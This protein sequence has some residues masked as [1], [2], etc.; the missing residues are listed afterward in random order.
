M[1][2]R[3]HRSPLWIHP[4]WW[5]WHPR[6]MTYLS[7]ELDEYLDG[8]CQCVGLRPGCARLV[9]I[10]L[11]LSFPNDLQKV[12]KSCSQERFKKVKCEKK[13]MPLQKLLCQHKNQFY[14][15]SKDHLLFWHKMFCTATACT[16]CKWIFGTTQKIW[17]DTKHFGTCKRTRH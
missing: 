13:L 8:G 4:C 6:R 17:T 7:M 3:S 2:P 15:I 14:W 16:I 12:K 1:R 9:R 11:F 10:K 5:Q